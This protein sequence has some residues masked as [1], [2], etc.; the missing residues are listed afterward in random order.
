MHFTRILLIGIRIL[1]TNVGIA[2]KDVSVWKR[3][4]AI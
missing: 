4:P 2:Y 1:L 3:H